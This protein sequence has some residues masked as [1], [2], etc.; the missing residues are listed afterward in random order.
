M[1]SASREY[2]LSA[3]YHLM[4][5]KNEVKSVEVADYLEVSK[6]SVSE[7]LKTLNADGLIDYKRYSRVKFT[8][9]GLNAAKGLTARHR[10]IESFL[11]EVKMKKAMIILLVL[12]M[13]A[14]GCAQKAE[15]GRINVVTTIGMITDIVQNVGKEK[16]DV[17][18]LMGPGVDPHL[19]KATEGDVT[20]LAEAD[21]I[22]YNGLH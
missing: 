9:K 17:H 6:P 21:I 8:K 11:K 2:Y 22:F 18:G 14:Y 1:E 3:I 7:M 12:S 16:V 15:D 19:Y 13:M 10:I 4:E 20:R 5:E